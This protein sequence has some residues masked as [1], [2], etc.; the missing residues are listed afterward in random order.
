MSVIHRGCVRGAG[1]LLWRR[2]FSVAELL[3]AMALLA[4]VALVV[5]QAF[6]G[7]RNGRVQVKAEAEQ[8]AE[9]LRCLRQQAI[10]EGRAV[11]LG[12]PS[13]GGTRFAS[14]G[15]YLLEGEVHPKVVRRVTLGRDRS[16]QISGCYWPELAFQPASPGV[17]SNSNYTL[18][19]WDPPYPQDGLLMFLPSGEV[20][21][22]LPTYQGEAAV[23]LGYALQ[24]NSSS[25]S[26]NPA[27]AL[28]Q[29]RG[30][31][32]VWCSVLGEVRLEGG[33]AGAPA[34]VTATAASGA[35]ADVPPLSPNTNSNP[36]FVVA[37][38]QSSPLIISPPANPNTLGTVAPGNTGTLRRQRYVSLKVTARDPDGDALFCQWSSGGGSGTFTKSGEIRMHYDPREQLWTATWAWH[39]PQSVSSNQLFSLDATI[40]DRRGGSAT[41]AGAISGGGTFRILPPGK[42]AFTRGTDTWM[43]NWDGSDPVIVAY[44]LTRPRWSRGGTSLCCQG[45]TG[46]L[47]VVTADGRSQTSIFSGPGYTSPGSFS[48]N[49]NRVVFANQGSGSTVIKEVPPWGGAVDDWNNDENGFLGPNFPVGTEPLVDCHPS[50]DAVVVSR[51]QGVA[52]PMVVISA[53]DSALADQLLVNGYDA[54]FTHSGDVM[55]RT[56]TGGFAILSLGG[57]PGVSSPTS[58]PNMRLP[59]GSSNGD[60]AVFQADDGGKNNCYIFFNGLT[61][62]QPQRLFSFPEA[63]QH[64]DWAD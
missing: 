35:L 29:A 60:Y 54:S 20:L 25:L 27:L 51:T 40:T 46:N 30:P 7:L 43:S 8:L 42:L 4:L 23:V 62:S 38:N 64:P 41:L 61:L 53:D 17:F 5:A 55:Y 18:A 52:G 28:Q 1:G 49:G 11:G 26:G 58:L 44:G 13:Q 56:A 10:T 34:R 16:I 50:K 32:V 57:G 31:V 45:P 3:V 9:V 39:P 24:V 19:N 37:A 59:R 36:T 33:L 63:C 12:I 2:A 47:V 15:Y 21:T 48:H 14:S 22:N 6:T